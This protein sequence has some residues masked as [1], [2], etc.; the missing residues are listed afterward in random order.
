MDIY[1]L[2]VLMADGTHKYINEL[3]VGDQIMGDDGS[4][5]NII[6]IK[7]KKGILIKVIPI[8][9]RP[10]I[11]PID[12]TVSLIMPDLTGEKDIKF[13]SYLEA[14]KY[15]QLGFYH[16][17]CIEKFAKE[18]NYTEFD[19]YKEGE[20]LFLSNVEWIRDP[21]SDDV[22]ITNNMLLRSIEDR[23][24]FIAA[25][26]DHSRNA[27]G[28]NYFSCKLKIYKVA[29]G[30][31]AVARSL[32]IGCTVKQSNPYHRNRG[33]SADQVQLKLFG[34]L[35]AI[36]CRKQNVS[37]YSWEM[38]PGIN[39]LYMSCKFQTESDSEY[40]SI[41]TDGNHRFLSAEFVVMHDDYIEK[42][43][44]S[45]LKRLFNKIT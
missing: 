5:R 25:I 19:A 28:G 20:R 38:E 43:K 10:F 16:A 44:R 6:S 26:I 37:D 12:S 39:A 30:I 36:P 1:T 29:S 4:I 13:K 31:A 34:D 21:L 33:F 42:D 9:G 22:E 11:I 24:N 15:T 8:A 2:Q 3:S 35:S 17:G 40:Y 7:K 45:I 41:I 32:G 14:E 27:R 23:R 18:I